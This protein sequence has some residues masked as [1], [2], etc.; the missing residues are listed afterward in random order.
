MDESTVRVVV[1][2]DHTL[3]RQSLTKTIEAE[4]GFTVVGEASRGDEV[5]DTVKRLRAQLLLL[6]ISMPG[7]DGLTLADQLHTQVPEL[8]ILF[9]TMHDD[10]TSLRRAVGSRAGGY[11][12][13]T[14][15]T[16]ELVEAVHAVAAGG[17]YLSQSV[18][19]R[20]MD[21]AAGRGHGPVQ[22]L[23]G[24]EQQILEL[25]ASGARPGEIA[26]SLFLSVK[27]VKNHLT[28]IYA[29]LD[30]E[31]GTQAVGEAYRLGLVRNQ[32]Q[33]RSH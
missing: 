28:S 24:R 5:L 23:T 7:V 33:R 13:K 1:A 2:D 9:V 11:V 31:T 15:T 26:D 10:D 16:E 30:V 14:A 22:Q 27:T 8:R 4:D 17:S 29:K 25:L 20:V 18:A 21:L 32:G 6:D 3:V 19:R 12:A